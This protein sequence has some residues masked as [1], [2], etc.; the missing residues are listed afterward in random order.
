MGKQ[1]RKDKKPT[2]T[3]GEPPSPA[4]AELSPLDA[5]MQPPDAEEP[6]K[7]PR[8]HA[9]L[10]EAGLLPW[11]VVLLATCYLLLKMGL[12]LEHPCSILGVSAPVTRGAVSKRY[13]ELSMCTHPDK[14]L[15]QSPDDIERGKLLF[16]RASGA[17]DMLTAATRDAAAALEAQRQLE[18]SSGDGTA[19][20]DSSLAQASCSTQLDEAI[21]QGLEYLFEAANEVGAMAMFQYVFDFFYNLCTF[22]Y[23]MTGTISS[24][25]LLMTFFTQ[26]KSLLSFLRDSGP[27]STSIAAVTTVIIG[28]LPTLYRFA[29]LPVLRVEAF[30]RCE[31][32]PFFSAE[33]AA[34]DAD[35]YFE[36][37]GGP[38]GSPEQLQAERDA[39]AMVQSDDGAATTEPADSTAGGTAQAPQPAA[40][41]AAAEEV[42]EVPAEIRAARKRMRDK[43]AGGGSDAPKRGMKLRVKAGE[44][45]PTKEQ[46]HQKI[47]LSRM[48]SSMHSWYAVPPLQRPLRELLAR[49]TDPNARIFTADAHQVQ[50]E[51]LL[52]TSKPVIPLLCLLA[53]G[54]VYN[55]I[56]FSIATSQLLHRLPALR[57]ESQHVLALLV[58]AMHT[59]VCAGKSQLMEMEK[60]PEGLLQLQWDWS[61][62]DVFAI[63]NMLLI[64]GSFATASCAYNEP[65]FCASFAAGLALRIVAYEMSPAALG[66]RLRRLLRGQ[67][68]E[69]VGLDH[70]AARAGGGVGAC[71]G[72]P[73]RAWL[74]GWGLPALPQLAAL[75]CKGALLLLPCLAAAQWGL[76]AAKAAQRLRREAARQGGGRRIK[77]SGEL[78]APVLRRRCAAAVVMH[79]SMLLLVGLVSQ[80][81]LNG[82]NSQLGTFL[83]LACAGCLFESLLASYDMRGRVRQF[84]FF[85][86]FMVL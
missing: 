36:V 70:V 9:L 84:I 13:R 77:I 48:L 80:Y 61:A 8:Y 4:K 43:E 15:G 22:Q 18:A 32:L 73:L 72:G 28:P 74:G 54:Q 63:A 42:E 62:R 58:G 55:G 40:A 21:W 83:V 45:A 52:S 64:G 29:V 85:V 86:M 67:N 34:V 10:P 23:D 76:R 25:L 6:P 69:F 56:F 78:L 2:A 49:R 39:M 5:A 30:V 27:I 37:E 51:L 24:V 7:G 11:W 16:Q 14:L 17:R 68:L 33:G 1:A 44:R 79:V 71:G 59:L 41:A 12:S 38:D 66:E 20:A 50:F 3:P 65:P 19:S 75:A 57:P 31:L 46:M 82:V 35:S 60:A 26:L 81:E 47:A 53:T